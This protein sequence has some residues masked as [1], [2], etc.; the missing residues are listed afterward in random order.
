M[1]ET[2]P[3]LKFGNYQIDELL[4]RYGLDSRHDIETIGSAAITRV[5]KLIPR[6]AL[7]CR[8]FANDHA[9]LQCEYRVDE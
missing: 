3:T 5:F 7:A 1:C 9:L 2:P 4:K 6:S 8:K